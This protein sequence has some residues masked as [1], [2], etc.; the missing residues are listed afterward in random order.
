MLHVLADHPVTWL[1]DMDAATYV[2]S[3]LNYFT[4]SEASQGW[5]STYVG[6]L[7]RLIT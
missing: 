6:D 7:G 2:A 1:F 5:P 3:G 4:H